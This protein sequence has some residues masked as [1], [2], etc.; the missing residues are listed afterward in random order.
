MALYASAPTPIIIRHTGKS[1][2]TFVENISLND[3][4]DTHSRSCTHDF[5]FSVFEFDSG[6]RVPVLS[7]IHYTK[8]DK[9]MRRTIGKYKV[10]R[11]ECDW[12]DGKLVHVSYY[13]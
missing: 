8:Y 2:T 10:T 6:F 1:I 9:I 3:L 12:I 7:R 11:C 13:I 4:F 5:G